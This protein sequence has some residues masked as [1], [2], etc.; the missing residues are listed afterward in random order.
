[1]SISHVNIHS[2]S[3][4]S[5]HDVVLLCLET[6]HLGIVSLSGAD[7]FIQMRIQQRYRI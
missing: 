3:L 4:C 2:D 7:I 5:V 6:Q 1:M